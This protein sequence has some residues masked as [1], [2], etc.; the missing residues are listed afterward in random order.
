LDEIVINTEAHPLPRF[1]MPAHIKTGWARKPRD[2]FGQIVQP[3]VPDTVQVAG[4]LA[5]KV[6]EEAVEIKT[7]VVGS[8]GT[9]TT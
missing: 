2:K 5:K 4:N 3:V 7:V 1:E 9:I 8:D 6:K